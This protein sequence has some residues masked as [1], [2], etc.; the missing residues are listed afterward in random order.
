MPE[1]N[2]AGPVPAATKSGE[3]TTT[4]TLAMPIDEAGEPRTAPSPV[5]PSEKALRVHTGRRSAADSPSTWLRSI[6]QSAHR[7]RDDGNGEDDDAA[8]EELGSTV[9]GARGGSEC[10]E[11][12]TA[13][14]LDGSFTSEADT[15]SY[16]HVLSRRCPR[17][18]HRYV[19]L[20]PLSAKT[21]LRRLPEH[22]PRRGTGRVRFG[23]LCMLT[24]LCEVNV[25]RA[26][27]A[28][29]PRLPSPTA[30]AGT[31]P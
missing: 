31:S 26:P 5:A 8:E 25:G 7:S 21:A 27:D 23:V 4:A 6:Y 11:T 3:L 1:L 30:P 2:E 10:D 20:C 29:S 22:G 14:S 16:H 19:L 12:E 17:S 15:R 24:V 13:R 18:F 28:R 9:S